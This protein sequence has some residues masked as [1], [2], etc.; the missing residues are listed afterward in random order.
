MHCKRAM[1][2]RYKTHYQVEFHN[3]TQLNMHAIFLL[4]TILVCVIVLLKL[5]W[6][7]GSFLTQNSTNGELIDKDLSTS[8]EWFKD[9]IRHRAKENDLN[10]IT[11]KDLLKSKARIQKLL[12]ILRQK[13]ARD[14]YTKDS[15]IKS[16]TNDEP[17]DIN[18]NP[19][20]EDDC[21]PESI[22][23]RLSAT[24]LKILA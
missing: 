15:P 20:L 4:T 9:A 10:T 1:P 16:E 5:S 12:T 2:R 7:G 18:C 22:G 13:P 24:L 3:R 21:D 11:D 14:N 17:T 6:G 19:V 8:T 23:T